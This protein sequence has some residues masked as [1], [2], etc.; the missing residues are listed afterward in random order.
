MQPKINATNTRVLHKGGFYDMRSE[1]CHGGSHILHNFS[2]RSSSN[3]LVTIITVVYNGVGSIQA[4]I[5]S[6]INQTYDNIEYVIVDGGSSDGTLDI[7]KK[8]SSKIDCWISESDKGIY[9]AMNKGIARSTG[10]A[11]IFINSGDT[12]EPNIV[13]EISQEYCFESQVIVGSVLYDT[14]R[15]FESTPKGMLVKNS[16]HHQAAF[17]P[18]SIFEQLG[19]F[20]LRYKV[21]DD[22]LLNS[23]IVSSGLSQITVFDGIVARCSSNGVSDTP[24]MTNYLEEICIRFEVY[25]VSPITLTLAVYSFFR[26][27]VKY[28]G[29]LL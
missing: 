9:D 8:Y 20:S 15:V 19:V 5:E 25:G 29:R 16:I 11:C 17:Y 21:L 7:I 10:V 26:F 14:G 6:V 22:Y 13:Y 2:E 12:I 18:L 3:P 27:L 4:T 28:V 24:R 23:R 1:A